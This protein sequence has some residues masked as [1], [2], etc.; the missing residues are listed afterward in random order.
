MIISGELEDS[1]TVTCDYSGITGTL[2][3]SSE[4]KPVLPGA[5]TPRSN[6][7]RPIN[8]EP[9]GYTVEDPDDDDDEMRE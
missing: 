3:Y 1:T 4:P 6:G 7:K 9:M 2:A 8:L 5:A